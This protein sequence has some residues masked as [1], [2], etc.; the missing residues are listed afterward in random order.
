MTITVR[1]ELG[2][3]FTEL[4]KWHLRLHCFICD[5]TTSPSKLA[6]HSE[7]RWCVPDE[8]PEMDWALP[9]IPAVAALQAKHSI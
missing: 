1:E 6:A 2:S 3:Y 7:V 9:D 8:L 4:G 5:A